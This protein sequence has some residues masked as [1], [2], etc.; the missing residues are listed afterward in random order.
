MAGGGGCGGGGPRRLRHQQQGRRLVGDRDDKHDRCCEPSNPGNKPSND[1]SRPGDGR[2]VRRTSGL[3]DHAEPHRRPVLHRRR[4]DQERHQGG[5]A[6]HTLETR[7]QNPRRRRLHAGERRR[8]RGLAL[9]R[10]RPLFRVRERIPRRRQ[11]DRRK[12][13]PQGRADNQRRR[14]SPSCSRSTPAGTGEGRST[15]TP[16][17]SSATRKSSPANCSSTKPS[18]PRSTKPSP[19]AATRAGTRPTTR[20]TSSARRPSSRPRSNPTAA[21]EASSPSA[22]GDND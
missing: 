2:D 17:S 10:H 9:R 15:S 14:H 21:T 3:H 20:T 18:R 8:V 4:Q 12:A 6:G 19:T 13:I 22:S 5:P 7:R 1:T 11:H 16:R